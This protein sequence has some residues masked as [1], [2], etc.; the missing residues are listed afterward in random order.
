MSKKIL[1]I[2]HVDWDWIKQRP[3]FLAEQLSG[4]YDMAVLY[5]YSL[6]RS[7]MTRNDRR[8]MKFLRVPNLPFQYNFPWLYAANRKALQGRFRKIINTLKPDITWLTHPVLFDYI[9]HPIDSGLIYDCMDDVQAFGAGAP[10]YQK[11]LGKLE[12]EL[13]AEASA[14]FASSEHLAR[15]IDKRQPCSHKTEVVRNAFDG[16]ILPTSHR[17][18]SAGGSRNYVICYTGTVAGWFDFDSLL[19]CVEEIPNIEFKI[20]GPV[21]VDIS[22]W[23]H[24]RIHFT[25]PVKHDELP[26]IADE[27]DC[28]IMPF[29]L[30]DLILS[31]D[32][33][34][35]YEYVNYGKPVVSVYYDE[36]RRFEPFVSFYSKP[37]EMISAIKDIIDSGFRNKYGE[38]ERISFLEQNSWDARSREI[39]KHLET[40]G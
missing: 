10:F 5:L 35:L 25:G 27:S 3:H 23:K 40:L 9:P 20:V 2:S 14:V 13:L 30:N 19:R 8:G 28:F 18:E 31:V 21:T 15:M 33:V 36:I 12:K 6:R 32:P 37:E 1:Y 17:R 16:K 11:R 7:G 39:M 22:G 24:D 26:G 29:K 34:K 4:D 38:E